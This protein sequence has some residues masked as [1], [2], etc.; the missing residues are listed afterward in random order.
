MKRPGKVYNCF[1]CLLSMPYR[2]LCN[3]VQQEG[4]KL[5][6]ALASELF[7]YVPLHK[8]RYGVLPQQPAILGDAVIL[9]LKLLSFD[10]NPLL[11]AP[12][13]L[14][15]FADETHLKDIAMWE[16]A[17]AIPDIPEERLTR[18]ANFITHE[19]TKVQQGALTL[20]AE[21]IEI[22]SSGPYPTTRQ[23]KLKALNFNWRLGL[24]LIR[25]TDV[26]QRKKGIMLLIYSHFPISETQYFVA[27]QSSMAQAQDDDEIIAWT[28]FLRNVPV[29]RSE[30][31]D[32]KRLLEALL[33][34]PQSYSDR[35]L[36]AAMERYT[37]LEGVA[38]PEIKDEL[39]LDLPVLAPSKR[40]R[41]RR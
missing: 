19:D 36:M 40:G 27:L 18:L 13:I 24:S 32:W 38:G 30:K 14:S 33:D 26:A 31:R 39:A 9:F 2:I 17:N 21:L 25:D 28:L 35:V 11:L 3:G 7:C 23:P 20:W 4:A 29:N 34:A 8:I 6:P 41:A 22:A 10:A 5:S 37:E 1:T 16:L 12:A 15:Y